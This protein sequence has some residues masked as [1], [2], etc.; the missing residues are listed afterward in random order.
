MQP[1]NQKGSLDNL[2]CGFCSKSLLPQTPKR[3]HSLPRMSSYTGTVWMHI[4]KSPDLPGGF[5]VGKCWFETWNILRWKADDD[6][7]RKESPLQRAIAIFVSIARRR[8]MHLWATLVQKVGRW[9]CQSPLE[10]ESARNEAI[11]RRKKW[12]HSYGHTRNGA[13]FVQLLIFRVCCCVSRNLDSFMN[14]LW[15]ILLK[16]PAVL[17]GP[18]PFPNLPFRKLTWQWKIHHLKMYFLLKTGILR[19]HVCFQGCI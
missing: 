12:C 9:R 7:F 6:D 19:C 17:C 1:S 18:S 16:C 3:P 15:S 5:Q 14:H 11:I 2:E 10:R 4:G 13:S 8:W